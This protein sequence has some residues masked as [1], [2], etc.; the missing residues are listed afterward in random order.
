M[1]FIARSILCIAA[2][3]LTACASTMAPTTVALP[4]TAYFEGLQVAA[5]GDCLVAPP[6]TETK[7]VRSALGAAIIGNVISQGVNFLGKALTEA[8]AAK[9]WTA[10]GSRNIQASTVEFPQCVLIVRGTFLAK[11]D[12]AFWAVPAGWPANLQKKLAAKGLVLEH[13]PEFIFEGEF[14]RSEDQSALALRPVI[15]TFN[16]PIGTRALRS[17]EERNIAVF[18]SIA[19]PGTKPTLDTNPGAAIVLGRLLPGTT[20]VYGSS[21][22]ATPVA[23]TR[24]YDSPWFSI[25]KSDTRKPLTVHAMLS[26]TQDEA[27]FLTFLGK[28]FSDSKVVAA[29]TATLTQV[30]VPGVKEQADKDATTKALGNASDADTKFITVLT[31]LEACT[32]AA[33]GTPSLSGG[34]EARAAMR[35]YFIA[36]S[37]LADPRNDVQEGM[38]DEIDLRVSSDKVRAACTDILK[39]VQKS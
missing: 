30:F 35:T 37:L 7:G 8:G 33:N 3:G 12:A 16:S 28:V 18:L 31:K 34:A 1:K 15:A 4:S 27:A 10:T 14:V 38:I 9:T 2:L 32:R 17:A 13:A 21:T 6:R 23:A 26:E 5:E 24:A 22:A 25:S 20:R 39:R 11:G 36:D 19:P 29:E